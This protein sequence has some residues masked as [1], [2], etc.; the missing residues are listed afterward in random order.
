ME[1]DRRVAAGVLDRRRWP[2][3]A[4]AGGDGRC[5]GAGDG[6]GG[7][8]DPTA[9]LGDERAALD[10]GGGALYSMKTKTKELPDPGQLLAYI[11]VDP[12]VPVRG[13]NRC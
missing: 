2:V 3:A 1:F 5:S 9:A 10:S 11:G 8:G 4:D 6:G 7:A 12:L 13:W